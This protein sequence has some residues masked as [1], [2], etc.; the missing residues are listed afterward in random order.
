MRKANH[1]CCAQVN[2]TQSLAAVQRQ[3]SRRSWNNTIEW[4][5][6]LR[7][8]TGIFTRS[9]DFFWF[10]TRIR[11]CW[12]TFRLR[13]TSKWLRPE[14]ERGTEVVENGLVLSGVEVAETTSVKSFEWVIVKKSG[15]V[16]GKDF[17]RWAEPKRHTKIGVSTWSQGYRQWILKRINVNF[18]LL[19]QC[20]HFMH[21]QTNLRKFLFK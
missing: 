9:T 3:R 16:M 21:W 11:S 8:T 13:S 20:N 14:F 10:Y 19:A 12:M 15:C 2:Y 1:Q 4:S 18:V 5:F 6:R 7:S 17:G